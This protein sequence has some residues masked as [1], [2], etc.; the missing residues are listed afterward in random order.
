MDLS[1]LLKAAH[2]LKLECRKCFGRT[3]SVKTFCWRLA[4]QQLLWIRILY[5]FDEE[6]EAVRRPA[7]NLLVR[8]LEETDDLL[9]ELAH[10][11][12]TQ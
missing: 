5:L 1:E 11:L 8:L 7:T 3:F 9:E 10:D 2:L 6:R 4:S 12:R